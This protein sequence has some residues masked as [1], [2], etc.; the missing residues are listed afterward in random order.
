MW[1]CAICTEDHESSLDSICGDVVNLPPIASSQ[2][3]KKRKCTW[4][5]RESLKMFVAFTIAG[6]TYI[7]MALLVVFA[8]YCHFVCIDYDDEALFLA[9]HKY[10]SGIVVTCADCKLPDL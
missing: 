6:L 1:K 7:K 5:S 10:K 4:A 2:K 9:L 3:A 8:K